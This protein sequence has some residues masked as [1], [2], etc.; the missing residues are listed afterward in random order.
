MQFLAIN[1]TSKT[2]DLHHRPTPKHLH[3]D[4]H[5]KAIIRPTIPTIPAAAPD[6]AVGIVPPAAEVAALT[7]PLAP[8]TTPDAPVEILLATLDPP[9]TTVEPTPTAPEVIVD[10]TPPA[11]LVT[12]VATLPP[13][14]T[15]V[16]NTDVT[17]EMTSVV[18]VE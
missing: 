3:P 10:P 5:Y 17:P 7:T 1:I 4:K 12:L 2:L 18:N 14:T 13:P 9:E 16:E 8:D 6:T 11:P 15:M